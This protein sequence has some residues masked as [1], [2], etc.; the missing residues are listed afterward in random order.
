MKYD[1][2]VPSIITCPFYL[3]SVKQK[4]ASLCAFISSEQQKFWFFVESSQSMLLK[5]SDIYLVLS[6]KIFVE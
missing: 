1:Q 3:E 4:A 2:I 5:Y 6:F